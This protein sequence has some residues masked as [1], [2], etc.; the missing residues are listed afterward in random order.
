MSGY[1]AVRLQPAG[2]SRRARLARRLGPDRQGCRLRPAARSLGIACVLLL[3]TAQP[4]DAYV[5]PGAGFALLSSF[6]VLFATTVAVR[7]AQGTRTV[8]ATTV[9]ALLGLR[10]TWITSLTGP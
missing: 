6:L 1:V 10:S 2:N 7:G 8:P 5:G 9:Q 3:A 4:A